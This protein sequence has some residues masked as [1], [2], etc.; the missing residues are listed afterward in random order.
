MIKVLLITWFLTHFEPITNG[1]AILTIKAAKI[2]PL[3]V[4]LDA[5]VCWKCLSFWVTFAVTQDIF[6]A[7]LVAFVAN[8]IQLIEN[9]LNS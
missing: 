9:K 8:M 2:K 4:L 5:L 7:I 6:K 1:I 3:I